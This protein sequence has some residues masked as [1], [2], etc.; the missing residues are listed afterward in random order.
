[1]K[2]S[3]SG[4]LDTAAVRRKGG[5]SSSRAGD[6]FSVESSSSSAHAA[7]SQGVTGAAPAHAISALLILQE[8]DDQGNGRSRTLNRADSMLDLLDDIKHGIL[9]GLIPHNKLRQLLNLT[10]IRPESFVDPR[11]TELMGD[12]E[13]RAKVELAK[14][15]MS[16]KPV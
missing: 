16:Q 9:V 14:I 10:K 1:M 7:T 11:L 12:I 3:G 5:V 13:L 8:V 4:K 6:S 15:E 2:I